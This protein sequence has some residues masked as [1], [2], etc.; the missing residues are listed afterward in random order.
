MGHEAPQ[1]RSLIKVRVNF[2][3]NGKKPRGSLCSEHPQH[4]GWFG[5]KITS[6]ADPSLGKFVAT[7]IILVSPHIILSDTH[8]AY[9]YNKLT[10]H[11]NIPS[12]TI[13]ASHIHRRRAGSTLDRSN[14]RSF[15]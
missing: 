4:P 10:E 6:A 9:P 1:V 3:H 12:I 8:P 15:F 11:T 14:V 2:Y 7:S 13:L 5:V